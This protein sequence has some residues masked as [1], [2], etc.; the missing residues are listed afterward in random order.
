LGEKL[1]EWRRERSEGSGGEGG[2]REIF[3]C[4]GGCEDGGHWRRVDSRVGASEWE[5]KAD[6][7]L[8]GRERVLG[9]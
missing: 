1:T 5:E 6:S 7:L 4:T 9:G 3:S 8:W 2:G